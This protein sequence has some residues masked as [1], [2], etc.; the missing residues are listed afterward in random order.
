LTYAVAA[1]SL[2]KVK[3]NLGNNTRLILNGTPGAN[4]STSVKIGELSGTATSSL[5]GGSVSADLTRV[6]EFE[7]GGLNTDA[8]FNGRILPQLTKYPSRHSGTELFFESK[9]PGDTTWYIPST[10]KLKKVGKGSWTV[11]GEMLFGGDI[12][13][14]GG[15]LVLGNKVAASITQIKVDTA[16]VLAVKNIKAET[17]IA[18]NI[19]TLSGSVTANS[20]SLTGSTLKMNVNSFAEADYDKIVTIGDMSTIAAVSANDLNVLDLTVKAATANAKINIIEVQGNADVTFNK[21]LV[22]GEDITLNTPQTVGAKFVY[23]WNAATNAGELLSLTTMTG[24]KQVSND[25]TIKSVQYYNAT[26]Q[27]VGKDA[28]GFLIKKT[29]Y[30]DGTQSIGK[31]IEFNR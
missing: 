30:T 4:A 20:I 25:K 7:V 11:N 19:G 10:L 1:T 15:T 16:A 8:V 5:E 21:V 23:S 3:V 22:N 26:G 29:T 2:A 17:G 27:I 14:L 31:T 18:I 24:L 9:T 6:T 12:T 28:Q 13:V